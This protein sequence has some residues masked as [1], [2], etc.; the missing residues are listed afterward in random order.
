MM[1]K[2]GMT[3]TMF[4]MILIWKPA[5]SAPDASLKTPFP[6]R[7]T[8]GATSSPT[9]A[10][11]TRPSISWWWRPNSSCSHY[12]QIYAQRPPLLGLSAHVFLHILA[13]IFIPEHSETFSDILRN[14]IGIFAFLSSFFDIFPFFLIFSE[15]FAA[16]F[17]IS[18]HSGGSLRH[19]DFFLR[20]RGK[21]FTL[22]Y[23]MC[24]YAYLCL[25]MCFI[26]IFRCNSM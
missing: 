4:L 8:S 12:I 20:L 15:L 3:P 17:C 5:I 23:I 11:I 6:G 14:T 10:P 21:A 7:R 24:V 9:E 25:S 2:Q 16:F 19:F 18:M 22:S 26:Y 13:R 1:R